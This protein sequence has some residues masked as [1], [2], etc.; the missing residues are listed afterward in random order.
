MLIFFFFK[1]WYTDFKITS[2]SAPSHCKAPVKV[3]RGSIVQEKS[4][5]CRSTVLLHGKSHRH[6][7]KS[8]NS[9]VHRLHTQ[10]FAWHTLN[11]QQ[12]VIVARV[13]VIVGTFTLHFLKLKTKTS[14]RKK[15][16]RDYFNYSDPSSVFHRN[17]SRQIR[18]YLVF[19]DLIERN[20]TASHNLQ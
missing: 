20:S 3:S 7:Q 13:M 17:P 2:F 4:D 16:A 8:N 1:P 9:S 10:H 18:I 5:I 19:K 12:M 11:S 15:K 14:P 6:S